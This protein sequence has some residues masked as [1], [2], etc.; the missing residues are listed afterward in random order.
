MPPPRLH[1]KRCVVPI[2]VVAEWVERLPVPAFSLSPRAR[3]GYKRAVSTAAK[4]TVA[5]EPQRSQDN[6]GALTF[7][8]VAC[9]L[10]AIGFGTRAIVFGTH[11][12]GPGTCAIDAHPGPVW[13]GSSQA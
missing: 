1:L 12:I 5:E 9:T 8:S 3:F 13:I 10:A 7:V 4:M 11:A 2:L 6:R